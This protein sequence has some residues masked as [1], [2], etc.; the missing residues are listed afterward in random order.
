MNTAPRIKTFRTKSLQEAI[1]QIRAEFGPDA[2]ILETKA[3]KR[4]VFGSSRIEVTASSRGPEK[5]QDPAI[6]P[7]GIGQAHD[8]ES[9]TINSLCEVPFEPSESEIESSKSDNVTPPNSTTE[10]VI[11]HVQQELL[12]AGIDA[13]IVENWMAAARYT[14]NPSVMSD[15]WT[16]RSEIQSWIRGFVHAAAPLVIDADKQ[17]VLAF[18]G[19]AGAGK[20]TTLAK[21]AAN[22][23]ME[24]ECTVGVVST[25]TYRAGSNELLQ[26]YAAVL[27]WEFSTA[28]TGQDLQAAVERMH[29][30]DFTL[31]DTRGW[32]PIDDTYMPNL[33]SILSSVSLARTH[34]VLPSTCNTRT[35]LR[36]EQG[37]ERLRPTDLILTK[38]DESH[39]LGAFFGCLQSTALPV[40]YLTN[41]QQIPSDLQQATTLRIAQQVMTR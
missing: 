37:F 10:L 11:A 9:P 14:N 25:D 41:G 31:I 22:L 21:I 40:S 8:Q 39:G 27:G 16:L 30:C 15:V 34:L 38:L 2:S 7:A 18:V 12:E 29:R 3:T 28:D 26:N 1:Q 36:C 19:P 32:S 13:G 6:E 35:F 5:H 4:G 17:Q 20:T 24:H 33:E 23:S